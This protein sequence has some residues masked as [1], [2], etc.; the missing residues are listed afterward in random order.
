VVYLGDDQQF[1][2]LQRHLP[3]ALRWEAGDA[4]QAKAAAALAGE[5]LASGTHDGIELRFAVDFD[6]TLSEKGQFSAIGAVGA[7]TQSP[8]DQSGRPSVVLRRCRSDE[9]LWNIAKAYNTTRTDLLQANKLKEDEDLAEGRL[10]LIP[11][12]R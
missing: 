12:R 9:S 6:I 4:G 11:R 1:Y 8:K 10:L 2:T 5:V 3:V 7:D